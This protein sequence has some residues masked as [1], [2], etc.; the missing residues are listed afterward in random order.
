M[1]KCFKFV[2]CLFIVLSGCATLQVP[3]SD[4]ELTKIEH[5]QMGSTTSSELTKSFGKP[6]RV[7]PLSASDEMWVYLDR[8]EKNPYQ[9]AS[10][11]IESKTHIILTAAWIPGSNDALRESDAALDHFNGKNSFEVRPL[12]LIAK[13]EISNELI[14]FNPKNGVS[15]RVNEAAHSTSV[16]GFELASATP[17]LAKHN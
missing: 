16:I 9:R 12:P 7:I 1:T 6:D 13:H 17:P 15:L 10:F 14:Y 3:K 4:I 5:L 8:Q 11:V 2:S